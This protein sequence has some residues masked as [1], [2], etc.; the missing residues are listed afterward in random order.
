[1][2][3]ISNDRLDNLK[4]EVVECRRHMDD[5]IRRERDNKQSLALLQ[6]KLI[7]LESDHDRH[8]KLNLELEDGIRNINAI[9]EIML[10]HIN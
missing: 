5:F 8:R 10:S 1:M 2:L 3:S 9:T 4:G 6:E 7:A